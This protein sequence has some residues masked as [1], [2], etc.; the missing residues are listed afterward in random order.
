MTTRCFSSSA[1]SLSGVNSGSGCIVA[2][3][4][5]SKRKAINYI[6]DRVDGIRN[7]LVYRFSIQFVLCRRSTRLTVFAKETNMDA[8]KIDLGG[9]AVFLNAA[10]AGSLSAAARRMGIAPMAATR[11]LAALEEGLGV[12]LMQR[13]TRSVSLTAEGEAFLP[14]ASTMVEAAEA[15]RAVISPSQNGAAGLLRVTACGSI[16]GAVI[17]PLI[18]TLLDKNPGLRV[19]MLLTDTVVDIVSTGVDIAV[20]IGE[21]RDSNLIATSLG[22]NRRILCASPT[23][24]SRRG[25]PSRLSDLADHDCI[26][27]TGTLHWQFNVNGEERAI[28]VSGRVTTSSIDGVADACVAGAGLAVLSTWH[29]DADIASGKLVQIDLK[30]ATPKELE[31]WAVYPTRRQVLP[32]VRVFVEA[33]RERLAG[34]A[35]VAT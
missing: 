10:A 33:M 1:P 6:N 23:Y 28:R 26:T 35:S 8:E 12:R 13:T 16:G 5:V 18:T 21:L 19:D 27:P 30:D 4:K 22:V 14:F 31:I 15:G 20:R 11:R 24:L 34:P 25:S 32:K 7:H 2:F 3:Q 17:M 29:A 9:V